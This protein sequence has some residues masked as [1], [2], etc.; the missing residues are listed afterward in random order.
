MKFDSKKEVTSKLKFKPVEE[1]DNLCLGKLVSVEV[2][3]NESAKINDQGVESNWEYAG[4]MIPKLKFNFESVKHPKQS[5]SE[6][7]TRYYTHTEEIIGAITKTGEPIKSKT[8]IRLYTSMFDRI[9]HIY[10]AYS[11]TTN[12]KPLADN[13]PEID[14]TTNIPSEARVKQFK[15]FFMFFVN[16]FNKGLD[17]KTPIFMA[18]GK[19]IAMTMKLVADYRSGKFL[20]F[21]T[22]VGEGFIEVFKSGKRP[23]IEIKPDERVTLIA[24]VPKTTGAGDTSMDSSIDD[25]VQKL[26]NEA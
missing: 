4:N 8:L 2:V 15:K 1:F 23:T 20:A 18:N 3:E 10:D 14:E 26:I 6:Y 13:I 25:E 12:Y 9:K 11:T 22:F 7:D 16:S 24:E 5:E 21:P 17:G 19:S